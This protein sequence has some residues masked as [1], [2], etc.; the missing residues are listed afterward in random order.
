[1]DGI[2]PSASFED[3]VLDHVF[4]FHQLS[5]VEMTVRF[6]FLRLYCDAFLF[7]P[8]VKQAS[9]VFLLWEEELVGEVSQFWPEQLLR[10]VI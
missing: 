4:H 9:F 6:H 2:L 1:M 3:G 5:P 7:L 8:H 10:I